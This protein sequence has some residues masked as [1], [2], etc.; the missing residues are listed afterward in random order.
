MSTSVSEL[1]SKYFEIK[2]LLR[3]QTRYVKR[4]AGLRWVLECE[5]NGRLKSE[6]DSAAYA[7]DIQSGL[8]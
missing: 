1:L 3:C 8:I 7:P 5:M 6:F 2:Q 4:G